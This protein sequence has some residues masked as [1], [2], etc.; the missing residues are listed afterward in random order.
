MRTFH[1]SQPFK[2]AQLIRN[3]LC[4]TRR[5]GE[6][7]GEKGKK[8]RARDEYKKHTHSF[9]YTTSILLC[10]FSAPPCFGCFDD[11]IMLLLALF[12]FWWDAVAA[13]IK[14]LAN[15][16]DSMNDE[17]PSFTESK[18]EGKSRRKIQYIKSPFTV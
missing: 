8:T 5:V 18:R 4:S 15:M 6:G 7:D 13:M 9:L 11:N 10:I 14:R 1:A 17:R 12:V 2:I 16:C 3:L